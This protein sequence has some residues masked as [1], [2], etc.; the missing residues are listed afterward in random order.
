MK[1]ISIAALLGFA[2]LLSYYI[3]PGAAEEGASRIGTSTPTS[4]GVLITVT[5]KNYC[6]VCTLTNDTSSLANSTYANLN[7]LHISQA[8]DQE[9]RILQ[10]L[11][12]KTLHYLPNKAGAPLLAGDKFRDQEIS[13]TGL[14]F[15]A[16]RALAVESFV[17]MDTTIL[18]DRLAP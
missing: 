11:A 18:S 6:L 17:P 13:V 10:A 1:R 14:F 2:L 8:R 9:G 5:G 3:A 15:E 7:A 12:G 4:A 16:E